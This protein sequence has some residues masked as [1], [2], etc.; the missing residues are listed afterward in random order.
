MTISDIISTDR[1]KDYVLTGKNGQLNSFYVP[2]LQ[3]TALGKF[4]IWRLK[5]DRDVKILITGKGK[6]TGTGKTTL[7]I[8]IARFVNWVRNELF[9]ENKEWNAENYSFM[10]VWEYLERYEKAS[11]GD[12]LITDEI[13]YM[14]DR[15]KHQTNENI[16]FSQAWSVL[17]YKNVVTI[18]TAP[19][20]M[21]LE[22]RV[23]EGADIWINV[24]FKGKANTYYITHNDFPPYEPQF[25][26]LR[27]NGR[28]ESLVWN[29]IEGSQFDSDYQHLKQE[30]KDIGIPGLS[31]QKGEEITESDL[32]EKEKEIRNTLVRNT[33]TYFNEKGIRKRFSQED[34]GDMVGVSQA[35]VSKIE[36]Q[37]KQESESNVSAT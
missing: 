27:L 31:Q 15:R 22:K 35:Q 37:L 19:G 33:L 36:R 3:Y 18:G 11:P 26:R 16:Y 25:R 6:S 29:P 9:D 17:R 14:A 10:D 30:K 21:D 4:I 2:D 24:I 32:N 20:L 1:G 7:A 28:R 34:I 12:A 5:Q 13:E 8:I 23:P